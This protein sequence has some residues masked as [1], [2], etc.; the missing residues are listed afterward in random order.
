M[1][2]TA[3]NL[4]HIQLLISNTTAASRTGRC[5]ELAQYHCKILKDAIL[6]QLQGWPLS[7]ESLMQAEQHQLLNQLQHQ[8]QQ[9]QQQQPQPQQPQQQPN[10]QIVQKPSSGDQL[11]QVGDAVRL[12]LLAP[13]PVSLSACLSKPSMSC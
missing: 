6:L 2:H 1:R 5:F 12:N 8:Q 10:S 13:V 11:V 9:P 7:T 3:V 4:R